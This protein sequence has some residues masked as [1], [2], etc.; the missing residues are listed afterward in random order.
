[1]DFPKVIRPRSGSSSKSARAKAKARTKTRASDSGDNHNL[2]VLAIAA[3]A[4][5][6]FTT[7]LSLIIYHTSGDIYLDRS[8]P[9]FLPDEKEADEEDA[10]EQDFR[11]S[12]SGPLDSD[13][14][15]EYLKELQETIDAIDKLDSPYV[16]SPL[17]DESLGIPAEATENPEESDLSDTPES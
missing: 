10:I 17:S 8:R 16:E 14:L 4:T 3:V 15:N 6:A 1:M 7:S 11:F 12:D 9:G 2:I 5:A 13:D